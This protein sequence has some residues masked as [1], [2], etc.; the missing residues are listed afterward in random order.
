MREIK[1]RAWKESTSEMIN[2]YGLLN[3]YAMNLSDVLS[4]T[5][6][7][8]MQYTGLKDKNGTEIYE[9]DLLNVFFTSSEKE[10][11]H[12][13]VYE[14]KIDSMYGIKL[15]FKKLLWE[16]FGYNQYPSSTT[17]SSEYGYISDDYRNQN[18]KVLAV[19]DTW[20]ENHLLKNR[21]KE[22]DYSNYIEVIGNI[23]E[24]P[25]LLTTPNNTISP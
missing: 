12:D 3:D 21:W 18:Y 10:H 11:I 17:L 16:S 6:L 5:Y 23:Y 25:D 7:N 22:N 9:G 24:S 1:F 8:V 2:W 14:V 19:K 20:G 13:C 4:G 15:E